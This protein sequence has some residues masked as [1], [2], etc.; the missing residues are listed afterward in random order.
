M[1]VTDL[2]RQFDRDRGRTADAPTEIPLNGW[3]DV[4]W[5]LFQSIGSDRILLTAAGVTFYVLLA[6]VPTL[7]AVVSIY[8]LFNDST[9]VVEQVSLLYGIVPTGGLDLIREQLI[10]LTAKP[11]DTLG[12]TLIISLSLALWS[13]SAGVKALFEAMNIAYHETERRSFLVVNGLGL[14]FT[15]GGALAAVL[16]LAIVLAMPPLLNVV[17]LPVGAEWAVRIVGYVVMLVI[18]WLGLTAL[19]R[20][21][22]SREAAK[23]RWITPGALVAIILLGLASVAFSWYVTNYSDYGEAYGSL[24]AL[25]G[26]MTWIWISSTIVILG[27]ELNSEVEH[28]TAQDSTT[29]A[30]EPLGKRGAHMADSIGE[31]N[32]LDQ[33]NVALKRPVTTRERRPFA[34]SNLALVGPVALLGRVLHRNS[35]R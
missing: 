7:T 31:V 4:A 27:A 35:A 19:Y 20:W 25:I 16:V 11:A 21:G 30:P 8:G 32:P 1:P 13:S 28:Q 23:W 15:L 24:G 34:W 3:K 14:V 18:I 29:G 9:T 10:R 17:P 12:L 6:L 26:L 33:E 22:P 2:E 5:R